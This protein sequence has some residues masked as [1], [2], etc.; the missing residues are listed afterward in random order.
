MSIAPTRSNPLDRAAAERSTARDVPAHPQTD[1][2]DL[3]VLDPHEPAR[4]GLA[5]LLQR[6]AW[7]SRCLHAGDEPRAQLLLSRHR[8][9]LAVVGISQYGP[10]VGSVVSGLREARPG[11]Q[12]VLTSHCPNA[13]IGDPAALGATAFVG[14]GATAAQII[15]TVRAALREEPMPLVPSLRS[16]SPELSSRERDVLALLA[17]GATN[18]EIAAQ[19]F[20]GPDTVKKHASSVYRK[21]GV[22]NRTEATQQAAG[23][24]AVAT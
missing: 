23:L 3:L 12:V 14:A 11:L 4:L 24:L 17:T 22:R 8:P 2:V 16:A 5:L 13:L 10:F 15:A 7:V 19:L 1:Q 18:R 9:A 21:L 20:L 6:E